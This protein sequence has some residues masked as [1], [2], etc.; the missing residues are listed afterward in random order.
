MVGRNRKS[1]MGICRRAGW[2][3]HLDLRSKGLRRH[4]EGRS[5]DPWQGRG[6]FVDPLRPLPRGVFPEPHA[7]VPIMAIPRVDL[8]RWQFPHREVP[9]D[10]RVFHS[11][12]GPQGAGRLRFHSP[13]TG[14]IR[15]RLQGIRTSSMDPS[16]VRRQRTMMSV[17][18]PMGEH[19]SVSR[20]ASIESFSRSAKF[21][22]RD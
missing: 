17:G 12:V 2:I 10:K 14:Q 15:R 18:F 22:P 9:I 5:P 20:P 3:P 6:Q 1:Q 8:A 19:D 21:L 7:Q 4:P 11:N 16:M 13:S